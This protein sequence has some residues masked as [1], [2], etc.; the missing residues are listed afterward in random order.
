MTIHPIIQGVLWGAVAAT[1]AA[2]ILLVAIAPDRMDRA[3]VV[4]VCRDG[5]KVFRMADGEYRTRYYHAAGPDI[6]QQEP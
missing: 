6:C 5:T 4:K 3:T 2:V 1:P